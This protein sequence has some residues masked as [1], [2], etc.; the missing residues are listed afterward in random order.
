MPRLL[1]L[2][3]KSPLYPLDRSLGGPRST[4]GR[5][6]ENS[7]PY[8]D[9]NY[10]SSVVQPVTG[11]YTDC[12]IPAAYWSSSTLNYTCTY[13][14]REKHRSNIGGLSCYCEGLWD[15]Q[16]WFDSRPKQVLYFLHSV[17]QP[18]SYSM[19]TGG[20]KPAVKWPGR[21]AYHWSPSNT[22][23]P[24][25]AVPCCGNL[26]LAVNFRQLVA[27]V[28]WYCITT[29]IILKPTKPYKK[30]FLSVKFNIHCAI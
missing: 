9:S 17:A 13:I 27:M 1:H 30:V 12:E 24:N 25:L 5:S 22:E 20:P 16:P 23:L 2:R 18:A 29:A 11:R 28:T 26:K 19:S 8:R 3:G 6:G 4:Y 7:W 21:E 14:S 15:G 10:N